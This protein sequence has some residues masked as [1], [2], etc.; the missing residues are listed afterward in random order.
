MK[1]YSSNTQKESCSPISSN[2][3]I[4]QGPDLPCL[5]LC[6][7]DTV[8]DVVYKVASELCNIQAATD[9]DTV[10]FSCLLNLCTTTPDTTTPIAA[11]KEVIPNVAY[12]TIQKILESYRITGLA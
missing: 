12:D 3:I 10:D 7:G 8:S 6:K 9:I 2:C 11:K 1:P 4:W 5:S